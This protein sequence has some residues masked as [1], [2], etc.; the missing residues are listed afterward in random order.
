MLFQPTDNMSVLAG[1]MRGRGVNIYLFIPSV[2]TSVRGGALGNQAGLRALLFSAAHICKY[3][4]S[5]VQSPAEPPP[6][7]P[8]SRVLIVILA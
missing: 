3:N 2:C 4:A 8:L 5:Y 7:A 1:F 6:T